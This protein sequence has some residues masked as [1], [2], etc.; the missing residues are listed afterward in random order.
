MIREESKDNSPKNLLVQRK[1][2]ME[3]KRL[4][5]KDIQKQPNMRLNIN[6]KKGSRDSNHVSSQED[7]KVSIQSP[8]FGE[9]N[10]QQNGFV[11]VDEQNQ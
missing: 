3:D 11:N 6:M 5:M 1:L 9:R 10:H 8:I 7:Q 2:K 4:S